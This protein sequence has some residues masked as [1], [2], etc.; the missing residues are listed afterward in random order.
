MKTSLRRSMTAGRFTLVELMLAIVISSIL[1]AIAGAGLFHLFRGW[2]LNWQSTQMQRDGRVAMEF[3]YRNLRA[4]D[5]DDLTISLDG[6]TLTLWHPG[7][8]SAFFRTEAGNFMYDPDIGV[9]ENEVTLVAGHA[10]AF[11]AVFSEDVDDTPFGLVILTLDLRVGDR[12]S[13]VS[14]RVKPRN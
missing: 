7:M 11:Q 8:T 10:H 3:L 12:T 14:T 2:H 6:E 9:A 13:I 4:V 1:T 5:Y